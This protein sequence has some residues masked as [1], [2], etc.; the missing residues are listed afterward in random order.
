MFGDRQGAGRQINYR[1]VHG[2]MVGSEEQSTITWILVKKGER[3]GRITKRAIDKEREARQIDKAF[4][5]NYAHDK[6][7]GNCNGN[8]YLQSRT[9]VSTHKNNTAFNL[10]IR[11]GESRTPPKSINS[12]QP[13]LGLLTYDPR[14]PPCIPLP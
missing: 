7:I 11:K 10:G 8:K 1:A 6:Q 3:S 2:R 13:A 14:A 4:N 9:L 5:Y 12:R